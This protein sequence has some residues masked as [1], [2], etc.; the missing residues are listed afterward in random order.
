MDPILEVWDPSGNPIIP[1]GDMRCNGACS[2]VVDLSLVSSGTYNMTVS[3]WGTDHTGTYTLQL[4]RI[5]PF[6]SSAVGITDDLPANDVL[7]PSTDMDFFTFTGQTGAKIKLLVRSP[8]TMDPILE[9]WDPFGKPIVPSMMIPNNKC[10]GACS[11]VVELSL[12]SSGAYLVA[13]SEWGSDHVGSYELSTACLLGPCIPPRPTC[14]GELATVFGSD[15]D[16]VLVG[17]DGDDVIVG[18]GGDD[19]ING[20]EGNDIICGDDGNDILRGS[21]GNDQLYGGDNHDILKGGPGND[22]LRGGTGFDVLHG[23]EGDDKL[24]GEFPNDNLFGGQGNDDLDGGPGDDICDGGPGN[25]NA[26]NCEIVN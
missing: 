26:V 6:P 3:E 23:G 4:E 15:G 20:L 2:L 18:L 12:P 13:L 19:V 9:V 25:D 1:G 22:I 11:I 10:N 24:Y 16:N 21:G 8:T 5:F 14:M 7:D 17:T